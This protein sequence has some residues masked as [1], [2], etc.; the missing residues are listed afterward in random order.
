M[1][2]KRANSQHIC[3]PAAICLP[4]L[5]AVIAMIWVGL[6]CYE[7]YRT[8][9]PN[10]VFGI[11]VFCVLLSLTISVFTLRM[12][13]WRVDIQA[14]KV[15]CKGILPKDTFEIN[16]ETCSI[17][18]D[19]HQQSGTTIWWICIFQGKFP[20]YKGKGT[21]N[22]INSIKIQPGFIRIMYS[23]EVYNTLL[24][25]LPKKQ[26]TAL[27]SARRAA[28]FEKNARIVF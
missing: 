11:G 7:C 2:K 20:P 16:Y 26:K 12:G 24:E 19:W 14:N 4:M 18:M 23:E 27:I 1:R 13:A 15:I 17:C 3:I 21:S 8:G 10:N 22:R 25:V 9:W 28:G 6:I 5:F